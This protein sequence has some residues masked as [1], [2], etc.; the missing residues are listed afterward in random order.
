MDQNAISNV[1]FRA[2][3]YGVGRVRRTNRDHRITPLPT[4]QPPSITLQIQ[5]NDPHAEQPQPHS[6]LIQHVREGIVRMTRSGVGV[7][8]CRMLTAF[9]LK[10]TLIHHVE[11]AD[12]IGQLV[13]N[14]KME[15][16]WKLRGPSP[17]QEGVRAYS[18][19]SQTTMTWGIC[20][21][22]TFRGAQRMNVAK[23][24]LMAINWLENAQGG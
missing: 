15:I 8:G 19:S 13:N 11:T 9:S 6:G 17:A 22:S 3:R 2:C 23:Y 12:L 5:I 14:T 16:E 1:L 4:N 10:R 18:G 20:G 24:G 21:G 7:G